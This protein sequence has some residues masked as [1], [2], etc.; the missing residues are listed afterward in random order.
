[1]RSP[2]HWPDREAGLPKR[3][4]FL[5]GGHKADLANPRLVSYGVCVSNFPEQSRMRRIWH[6]RLAQGKQASL[7]LNS[8]ERSEFLRNVRLQYLRAAA[9]LAVLLYH[10]SV[11]VERHR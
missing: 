7:P 3:R 2:G 6:A 10:A 5:F 11:V 8:G 1:M 4:P 9:A